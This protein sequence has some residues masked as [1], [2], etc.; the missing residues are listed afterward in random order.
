MQT[1]QKNK[2]PVRMQNFRISANQGKEDFII[3]KH[4]K[5]TP[6]PVGDLDF[7]YNDHLGMTGLA[8]NIPS[9][10]HVASEQLLS[11]KGEVAKMSGVKVINTQRQGP[12]SKQE[13]LIRDTTS[14]MKIVLWQDYANNTALEICKTYTFTNLRLKATK[15]ER[16]LNTS[17]SEKLLYCSIN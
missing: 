8:T 7:P 15:Y 3:L 2:R 17:K 9:L 10:Q 11:V 4:T 12:L 16:Y 6:L 14:S 1:L 13:I 5:I